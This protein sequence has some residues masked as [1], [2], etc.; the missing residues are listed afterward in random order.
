MRL[1]AIWAR[2][3]VN[4]KERQLTVFIATDPLEN[5]ATLLDVLSRDLAARY[6][7]IEAQSRV[8]A[9]EPCRAR[10]PDCLILK[11]ALQDLYV[12]DA[13]KKLAAKEGSPAYAVF[14]LFDAGD[15][16][17]VVEAMKNGAHN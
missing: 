10:K 2:P 4:K 16:Q 12:L 7:G 5:R 9:F 11:G 1:A 6:L 3:E 8:R 17:L 15:A 13:L 14:V